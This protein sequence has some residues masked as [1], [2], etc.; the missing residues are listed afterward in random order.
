VSYEHL[1][2][3]AI[4]AAKDNGTYDDSKIMSNKEADT[5]LK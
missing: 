1:F 4:A 2:P 5:V 3:D